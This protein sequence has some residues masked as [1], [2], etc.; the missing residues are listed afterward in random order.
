MRADVLWGTEKVGWSEV[1][2]DHTVIYYHGR[3][4]SSMILFGMDFVQISLSQI[5]TKNLTNHMVQK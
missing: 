3:M 4:R 5:V 2:V 1:V